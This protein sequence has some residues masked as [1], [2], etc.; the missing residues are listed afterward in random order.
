MTT[1]KST[2]KTIE[3]GLAVEITSV[4]AI[5]NDDLVKYLSNE[6]GS[7]AFA[8]FINA[9]GVM[10][11]EWQTTAC[12]ASEALTREGVKF[13]NDLHYFIHNSS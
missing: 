10:N 13:I 4:V 1:V 9:M 5:T 8:L 6:C 3:E 2:N 11:K 7:E 12:C